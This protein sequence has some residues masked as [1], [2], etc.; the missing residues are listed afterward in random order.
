MLQPDLF[1]C[2]E[3]RFKKIV[4][5]VSSCTHDRCANCSVRAL[6]KTA[7]WSGTTHF[8]LLARTLR[9]LKAD[10]NGVCYLIRPMSLLVFEEK[11]RL[12]RPRGDRAAGSANDSIS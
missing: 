8:S 9:G 6:D 1:R 12:R 4:Q 10:R 7:R 3:R 2:L 5:P 11:C